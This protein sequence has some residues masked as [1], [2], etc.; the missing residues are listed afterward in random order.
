MGD[1]EGLPVY[2]D[3][4]E[5]GCGI[6]INYNYTEDELIDERWMKVIGWEGLYLISD[7]GR[8][9]SYLRPGN[10]I[11]KFF[12][13]PHL[14]KLSK[15]SRG[16]YRF[17]IGKDGKFKTREV[18]RLVATHYIDNPKNKPCVNH[19]D[20]NKLNN[21]YSNLEWA[22]H[23]ENNQH[24]H[25]IGLNKSRHSKKQKEAVRKTGKANK[26]RR[27]WNKGNK[28]EKAS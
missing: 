12:D 10:H 9:A 14:L 18:H 7:F 16:Y 19:K 4:D 13:L 15:N 6:D 22:T 8:V 28:T 20:G 26:G 25:D 11:I 21:H 3:E 23:S 27:A 1:N 2:A 17:A 24:A 5:N